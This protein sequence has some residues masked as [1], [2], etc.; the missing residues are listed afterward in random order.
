MFLVP[1]AAFADRRVVPL[2]DESAALTVHVAGR[3]IYGKRQLSPGHTRD[4]IPGTSL[5]RRSSTTLSRKLRDVCQEDVLAF[6]TTLDIQDHRYGLF[7][8]E[9][10]RGPTDRRR[11]SVPGIDRLASISIRAT[12]ECGLR[13]QAI[14][15]GAETSTPSPAGDRLGLHAMSVGKASKP[16][17]R[18]G[19]P[20][21]APARDTARQTERRSRGRVH[22]S[23]RRA[24]Y[25]LAG[26][27]TP[28][29]PMLRRGARRHERAFATGRTVDKALRFM[30]PPRR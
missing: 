21:N 9:G 10:T 15:V 30:R 27:R 29:T 5:N 7:P 4:A 16:L 17:V 14:R 26:R 6:E 20:E 12:G 2:G 8:R 25:E 23:L 13:S 22:R 3:V 1:N 11:P 18:A 28:R 24:R 19:T